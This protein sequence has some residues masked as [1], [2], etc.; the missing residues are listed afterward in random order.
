MGDIAKAAGVSKATACY[1]LR[2]QPGPSKETRELV[3]QI[4]RQLG[5]APDARMASWMATVRD[6]KSK[7]LL[8]IAWLNTTPEKDGWTRLVNFISPYSWKAPV[9]APGNSVIASRKF[10]R[11][12]RA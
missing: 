5:Y 2:N 12:S 6:A 11:P 9:S 7:E 10:G 8:P 1:V 4:A 3:F